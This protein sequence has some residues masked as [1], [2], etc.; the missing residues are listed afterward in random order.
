MGRYVLKII[1][2]NTAKNV[3]MLLYRSCYNIWEYINVNYKNI[4]VC[5]GIEPSNLV[6]EEDNNVSDE[7]C[8]KDIL[9][10]PT[11][12]PPNLFYLASCRVLIVTDYQNIIMICDTAS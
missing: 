3:K 11:M 5:G 6:C 1:L 9:A 8:S 12:A 4:I 7:F 10:R 2:K